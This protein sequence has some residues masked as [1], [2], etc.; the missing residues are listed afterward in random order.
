SSDLK[1][2]NNA[3]YQV[4]GDGEVKV[5]HWYVVRDLGTALGETDRFAPQRG[6]PD[7]FDREPFITGTNGGFVQFGYKGWHQELFKGMTLGD[8]RWA[9]E[10]LGQLDTRQWTDAFRAGGYSSALADRF[11]GR[12]QQKIAQGR[13]LSQTVSAQS[14]APVPVLAR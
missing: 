11:T 12:L 7:L 8:V 5:K 14:H 9:S 1:N 2:E 6:D 4:N 3:L 13:Q 10:L